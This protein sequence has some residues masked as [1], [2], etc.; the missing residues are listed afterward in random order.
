M[1]LPPIISGTIKLQPCLDANISSSQH[2]TVGQ[3]IYNELHIQMTKAG[4]PLE[5]LRHFHFPQKLDQREWVPKVTS[6]SLFW[7]YNQRD[8]TFYFEWTP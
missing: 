7:E 8:V 1:S 2:I 6:G 5:R 3:L 4:L